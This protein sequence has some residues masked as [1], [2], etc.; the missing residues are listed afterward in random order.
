MAIR[1]P[2][3]LRVLEDVRAYGG[4]DAQPCSWSGFD[5]AGSEASLQ[6]TH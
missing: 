1:W 5:R 6:L 4:L 2:V 3:T